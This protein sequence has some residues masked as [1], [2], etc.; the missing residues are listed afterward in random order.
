MLN[1]RIELR[2]EELFCVGIG[3]LSGSYG[4]HTIDADRKKRRL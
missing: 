4:D 2:D 3:V 1:A